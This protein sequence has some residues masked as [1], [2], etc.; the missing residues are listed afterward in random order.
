MNFAKKLFITLSLSLL[1]TIALSAPE[2][3]PGGKHSA[4]IKTVAITQIVGHNSLDAV[5]QG[6]VDELKDN[7][8]KEGENLRIIFSNAQGSVVVASQI[9]QQFA[10]I[11]PDLIIAIATPSAQA[12][13]NAAK[14][15][16]IPVLF[17]AVTDPVNAK[18]VTNLQQPGGDVTGT[19]SITPMAEQIAFVKKLYPN[20]KTLG[21][22]I[23]SGETNSVNLLKLA[24]QSAA[25][26]NIK[27][28]TRNAANSAEV[29]SAVSSLINEVDGFFLLQ[30]N[31]ITSALP[32]VLKTALQHK[33]PVFSTYLV[34]VEKGALAG[35]A[36]DDYKIGRQTGKL[37]VRLLNGENPGSIPV[38]EPKD[39]ESAI[40]LDTAK[41]LNFELTPEQLRTF[42]NIFP[43]IDQNTN[44][45]QTNKQIN[46]P[47]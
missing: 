5:R 41:E 23:N 21:V 22:L 19:Q 46:V 10:A 25:A 35:L 1:S 44:E 45:Q 17:A 11:K 43:K 29:Q 34:A 3:S 4:K 16:K 27:I 30:D 9:A 15:T 47:Q 12:V 2:Q 26:E 24:E 32:I 20:I 40:N 31:T 28:T 18:L 13:I 14:N 39:L 42:D 8:F 38:E 36:I 7:G 33:K 37:A 6:I